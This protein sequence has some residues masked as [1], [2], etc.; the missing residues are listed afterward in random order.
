MATRFYLPSAGTA[1]AAPGYGSL[2]ETTAS[3]SRLPLVR[4]KSDTAFLRPSLAI[5]VPGPYDTLFRQ[6]V[7][8]DTLLSGSIGGNLSA[9]FRVQESASD[10]DLMLQVRVAVVS[11][12]GSTVRGELYSGQ[13]ATTVSATISDNNAEFSFGSDMT[14]ILQVSLSSVTAQAGDRLL[15]EIGVRGLKPSGSNRNGFL[16]FGDPT[17]TADHDLTAGVGTQLVPWVEFSEDLFSS[18][19]SV[20]ASLTGSG[21]LSA[22]VV[23]VATTA[24]ALAGSG[25]FSATVEG[26]PEVSA[27]LAGSGAF[28]ATSEE[29]GGVAAALI[30]SGAFT[31]DVVTVAVTDTANRAGGR[32]RS[33]YGVATWDPPVAT[34]PP[35][36]VFGHAVDRANAFGAATMDGAQPIYNVTSAT[37]PRHRDRI[38]VGGKDITYWR[39]IP[40]PLPAYQLVAPLLYGPATLRLP[41][42]APAF[43]KP[44]QGAL[45]WLRTEKTVKI[46]RV[47]PETGAVVGTDYKGVVVAFN[48][49]GPDLTVE[50]GG[51][52]SG[53]AALREK[54]APIFRQTFDIGRYADYVIRRD[55][56]LPF[57][58]RM[59]PTTGIR[60]ARFGGTGT[61]DYISQLCA[62]AWT[63][64][65]SQWTIMPVNG[66]Y[67]MARKDTTTIHATAYLDD[68]RTVGDLRRD[69]AEEPNRIFA[70]GITPNGQRVR[71]GVYPGLKQGRPAPYPFNDDRNFGTGTTDAATD[72]GDGVTVMIVRLRVTKFLADD[73]VP[74]G[75]DGDV[76]AAIRELQD[77]AGL[78]VTGTMTPNTWRALYDLDATGFSLRMAHIEPAAQKSATREWIRAASGA[79]VRRNPGYKPTKLKVD[80]TVDLGSGFT[81]AQM[82]EWAAAEVARGEDNWVGTITFHTGALVD[83]AHAPGDPVTAADVFRARDLRPNMN[84][85]L[86]LFADGIVVHVS[87][88][89]VGE[90]GTV[91]ATVD[92]QARDSMPVWE[93]IARNR[94]SRRDPARQWVR[95]HRAS[96]QI[97]DA[98]D[99][100]DEVGG[101][102]GSR[103]T[104]PAHEWTVFEVVAGQEGTVA[105]LALETSPNAEFAVGVFGKKVPA[106]RLARL[107]GNPLT[108]A[109][110]EKWS[111]EGVR[112]DLDDHLLLYAA[113]DHDDPCGYFPRSKT[114]DHPLT[115]RWKDD[116]G[117]SYRTFAQ[118]VL[119]VAVYA[120]RDTAIPAGR[121]MWPQLEAAV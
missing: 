62:R 15:V 58:P 17:A 57:Q 35:A 34:P 82:R 51:E 2:W 114:G 115:G 109:G 46:Q 105:R 3:A 7:S 37:T 107:V 117:F 39:G 18:I 19:P 84:L 83:G 108:E 63:R 64:S 48:T 73:D 89:N 20:G 6:W 40:T 96:G 77:V 27:S 50:I 33:G 21:A 54:Q 102:L 92:T 120:D 106:G 9:V 75:Y 67:R 42:V 101:L 72:T 98:I 31:A 45:S 97:K 85:S 80:R 104:V 90:D 87:G 52:A 99:G 60:L 29:V 47:D 23:A 78:P 68:A 86:P 5:G 22:A 13:T 25:A 61:L 4:T 91:T 10:G 53:R 93:V 38:I 26:I 59:G 49:S 79:I 43:E 110:S 1:P 44:G 103:V 76:A 118:K 65:G 36:L 55:L 8:S 121:V 30:G 32:R 111:D 41:Q 70:T 66:T 56:G 113:G 88:I 74:G 95:D 112:R 28:T 119:Y 11:G 24:A 100:W 94:E 14:R 69:L 71:F 116:A 81:I 16:E 12:D